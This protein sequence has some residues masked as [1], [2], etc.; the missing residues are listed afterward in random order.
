MEGVQEKEE[1]SV[2]D[3]CCKSEI[4]EN[5][6]VNTSCKMEKIPCKFY[7]EGR[8]RFGKDCN[9][10]HNPNLKVNESTVIKQKVQH[11]NT[12]KQTKCTKKATKTKPRMRT[13]LDVIHRIQWDDSLPEELIT[14]GYEDRFKGIQV[15]R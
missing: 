11:D 7:L 14:I 3:I 8:C 12:Q 13:A 10:Y 4:D 5:Y 15:Q 6:S 9:N 1:S 2:H